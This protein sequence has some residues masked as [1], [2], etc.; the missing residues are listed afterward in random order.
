MDTPEKASRTDTA[1]IARR[2][3]LLKLLGGQAA[4]NYKA[5]YSAGKS[6]AAGDRNAPVS[7]ANLLAGLPALKPN[8]GSSVTNPGFVSNVDGKADAPGGF[9]SSV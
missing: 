1:A 2:E 7:L 6:Y 9:V 3:K 8:Y 5:A 4:D